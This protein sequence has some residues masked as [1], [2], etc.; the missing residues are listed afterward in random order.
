MKK[1]ILL[2]IVFL[3]I[4]ICIIVLYAYGR[5]E[6]YLTPTDALCKACGSSKLLNRVLPRLL[7]K[8][9]DFANEVLLMNTSGVRLSYIPPST[10]RPTS[11][12]STDNLQFSMYITKNCP[13][14]VNTVYFKGTCQLV[15]AQG[16]L[17]TQINNM[18]WMVAPDGGFRQLT[19]T[20]VYVTGVM[21][22]VCESKKMAL[23]KLTVNFVPQVTN[24]Q[25]GDPDFDNVVSGFIVDNSQFVLPANPTCVYDLNS[26][27]QA[28]SPVVT[29]IQ[30]FLNSTIKTNASMFMFDISSESDFICG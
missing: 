27:G 6:R 12:P 26:C 23:E 11:P 16:D 15:V 1:N 20:N 7:P 10:T 22:A 30:N 29:L 25:T 8:S 24:V 3:I 13:I 21:K 4:L 5:S 19:F 28:C 2:P 9:P 17:L 14:P 18:L